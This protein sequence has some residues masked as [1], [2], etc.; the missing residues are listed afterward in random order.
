MNL[1]LTMSRQF[2]PK[3]RGTVFLIVNFSYV[4]TVWR[5]GTRELFLGFPCSTLH[6]RESAASAAAGYVAPANGC[7]Y[8]A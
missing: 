4:L 3:G 7:S 6:L 8:T 1:L 5:S 2:S